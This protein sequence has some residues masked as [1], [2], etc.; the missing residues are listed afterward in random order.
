MKKTLTILAL[1][2]CTA[3]T[4]GAVAQ[5]IQLTKFQGQRIT[6]VDASGIFDIKISQ[7]S[8]TYATISFPKIYENN[9]VFNLNSDGVV[10]VGI[11]GRV[12]SNSKHEKFTLELVCSS[13][14]QV[15]LSGVCNAV[16]TTRT[17]GNK[18]EI[19]L[20]G[21]SNFTANDLITISGALEV[22]CSGTAQVKTGSVLAKSAS[23]DCSGAS[24]VKMDIDV[25]SSVEVGCSGSG[26]IS[27]S[28]RGVKLSAEVSGVSDCNF[29][30]LKV[31][32]VYCEVSGASKLQLNGSS[33]VRGEASGASSVICKGG[34]KVSVST[35]GA[36]SVSTK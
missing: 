20:S 14:E 34:A 3:F 16:V 5:N 2:L 21:A 32:S 13:L 35:S 29:S 33:E 15:E 23:V 30:T 26:N 18:L 24:E 7:G 9:I 22:S 10:E 11:K 25:A 27:L 28:G 19:D 8:K 1:L 36:A 17:S 12:R 4:F 6:G 31:Q